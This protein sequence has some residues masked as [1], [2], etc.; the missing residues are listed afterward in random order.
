MNNETKRGL[1]QGLLLAR[2]FEEK[3]IELAEELAK[4]DIGPTSCF[5]QEA[6]PVGCCYNLDKKDYVLPS[7]RSA[8]PVFL[9]K[10]LP[11]QRI[12][13]EMYAK[14]GGFSYGREISSHI[15]HLDL[16]IMGGTGILAGTL[17]VSAGVALAARY[18][19]TKNIA[20]CFI[21]DGASNREEFYTG[22]N[23]AAVK[24]LPVVFVVE[25]NQIAEHTPI[26]K[27]L[28][29]ENIADRSAAFGIP[30][31]IVDGNDI[32]A[33][34][35]TAREAIER[36]RGG[37][38]PTIIECKTCRV[39][40]MSE[41]EGP[42]QGL[43]PGVIEEWLQKDPVKRMKEHMVETQAISEEEF[44]SLREKYQKEVDQAFEI[45]RTS[46][47]ASVEKVFTDVY[48]EGGMIE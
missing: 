40:P 17:T 6:I 45:A 37:Q 35:E 33:V 24:K 2:V 26:Q 16:G 43:P 44:T 34:Y 39:R 13:S 5:G 29:I 42:E 47:Y 25:S 21:G 10:G 12:A 7:I 18:N 36:A 22:I 28:P 23:F 3:K 9:T 41:M 31:K 4:T 14:A 1:L 30:G 15:T 8:W 38:G 19:N 46:D 32:M 11:V 27:V 48:A 20:V